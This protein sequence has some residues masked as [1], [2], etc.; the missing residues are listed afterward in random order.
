LHAHIVECY[1][2]AEV[3]VD[4]SFLHV[5]DGLLAHRVVFQFQFVHFDWVLKVCTTP[6]ANRVPNSQNLLLTGFFAPA[7][8]SIWRQVVAGKDV[9][10]PQGWVTIGKEL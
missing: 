5:L 8:R 4:I 6:I 1:E 7:G 9:E 2:F 10:N 3:G